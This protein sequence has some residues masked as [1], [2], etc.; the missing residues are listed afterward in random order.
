MFFCDF[1]EIFKNFMGDYYLF[2]R[3]LPENIS[4]YYTKN[5]KVKSIEAILVT[6]MPTLN[7]FLSVAITLEAA[8]QN[9]FSNLRDLSVVEFCYCRILFFWD[10]Q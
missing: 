4:E 9:N 7:I 10:S 3:S 1:C 8:I 2:F 6:L 5:I